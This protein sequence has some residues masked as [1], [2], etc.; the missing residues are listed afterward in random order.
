MGIAVLVAV[1][2]LF[3]L[4]STAT[5]SGGLSHVCKAPHVAHVASP[6]GNDSDEH[7]RMI[8]TCLRTF[9]KYASGSVGPQKDLCVAIALVRL[10]KTDA[11][12]SISASLTEPV[13][14]LLETAKKSMYLDEANS[15]REL[16]KPGSPPHDAV[17][18]DSVL[19]HLYQV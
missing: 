12:S 1:A 8:S 11:S 7:F 15:E 16:A 5:A 4:A 17:V 19:E 10:D 13:H 3:G 2:C 6:S 18:L 9:N 14:R